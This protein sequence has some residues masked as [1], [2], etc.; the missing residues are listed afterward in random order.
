M[1]N[2][3]LFSFLKKKKK[4]NLTRII[5]MVMEKF[6]FRCNLDAEEGN[7]RACQPK[8]GSLCKIF[9]FVINVDIEGTLLF[10]N[11]GS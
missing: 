4:S 2:T 5:R 6:P 10:L 3:S 8:H 9:S 1:I 7:T 11:L